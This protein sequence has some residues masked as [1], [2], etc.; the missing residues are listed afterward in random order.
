MS[1]YF[2]AQINIHDQQEYD[3]YLDGYDEVFSSFKGEVVAVDDTVTVLEGQWP[4]GRTVIIKF[5]NQKELEQWYR[6]SAYR[7]LVKHR[8]RASSANIVAV[9]GR[10]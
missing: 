1:C 6:S 2:V 9:K 10:D 4:Y 7:E 8:H 3:R 5:P